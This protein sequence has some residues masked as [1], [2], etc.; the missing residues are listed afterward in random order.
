MVV[1][2]LWNITSSGA[3]PVFE[4]GNQSVNTLYDVLNTMGGSQST[5]TV[6]NGGSLTVGGENIGNYDYTIFDG[7]SP[8]YSQSTWFSSTA[9]EHSIVVF[10]GDTTLPSAT[11]RPGGRKFSLIFFVKGNCVLDSTTIDMNHSY[12][13]G[14][15]NNLGES[16]VLTSN[17]TTN[18]TQSAG[19]GGNTGSVNAW[20]GNQKGTSTGGTGGVFAGG[21]GA[22]WNNG[23]HRGDWTDNSRTE[24][25]RIGWGGRGGGS[26]YIIATGSISGTGSI[27]CNGQNGQSLSLGSASGS[28]VGAGGGGG[29]IF[30]LAGGTINTSNITTSVSGGS[31]GGT[32]G[33]YGPANFSYG[34][35]A[36]GAS[37]AETKIQNH[38]F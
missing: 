13:A 19:N 17:L 29:V 35:G 14:P 3:L 9:N 38:T 21:Q 25:Y 11:I 32:T 15:H 4:G 5:E 6:T 20:G 18:N 22:G 28:G 12:T 1:A 34:G 33:S 31:G 7:G 27:T 30:L 26:V 8:S 24:S 23:Q 2:S 10:K 36:A 37:G 16:L